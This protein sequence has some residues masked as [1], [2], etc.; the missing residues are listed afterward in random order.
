MST[1]QLMSQGQMITNVKQIKTKYQKL[2]F[3]SK[4]IDTRSRNIYKDLCEYVHYKTCDE[5]S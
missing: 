3:I 5:N 1:M 2:T 4:V